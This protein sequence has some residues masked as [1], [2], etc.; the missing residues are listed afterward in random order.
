M[1]RYLSYGL[2]A[3]LLAGGQSVQAGEPAPRAER[4]RRGP[5]AEG[6]AQRQDASLQELREKHQAARQRFRDLMQ[7]ENA[8]EE[9]LIRA[10]RQAARIRTRMEEERVRRFVARR[11]SGDPMPRW[12]REREQRSPRES[13]P[14]Y[15]RE[16]PVR[17]PPREQRMERPRR[18]AEQMGEGRRPRERR[19]RE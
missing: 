9:E 8:T 14:E 10:L 13:G 12:D 3:A 7:D 4:G 18:P 2:L 15:R 19:D 16:R 17:E 6:V 5:R 1:N 11:D